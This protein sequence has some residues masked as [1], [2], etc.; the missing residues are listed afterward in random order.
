M[1]T[2]KT[3]QFSID[4]AAPAD[5]VHDLMIGDASYR[6][7]TAAFTEGSYYEGS[8]RE[9]ERIRFMSPS[10]EGMVAEIA[11]YTPGAFISIRILGFIADGQEDTYSEAV[12]SW[13]PAYEN[14]RFDAI[15]GGTRLVV[16]Q[17]VFETFEQHMTDT[18][19]KALERLKVLCE[20]SRNA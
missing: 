8:W 16:D 5:R 20:S 11:K 3:L 6:Q 10:G 15:P 18:W 4:I 14:Y 9:G 2:M 7:W 12:T 17:D 19:P 13:A 1:S